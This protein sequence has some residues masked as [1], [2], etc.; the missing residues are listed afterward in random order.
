M[1]APG[2]FGVL[3]VGPSCHV[4]VDCRSTH[5]VGRPSRYVHIDAFRFSPCMTSACLCPLRPSVVLSAP[6]PLLLAIRMD[7]L[8][9]ALV[10]KSGPTSAPFFQPTRRVGPQANFFPYSFFLV[11]CSPFFMCIPRPHSL[12]FTKA[13]GIPKYKIGFGRGKGWEIWFP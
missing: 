3:H 8:P 5:M 2:L 12:G 7:L 13:Q 1:N 6:S 4:C 11:L 10:A 9:S